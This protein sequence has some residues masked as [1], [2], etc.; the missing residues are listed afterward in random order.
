M[1][2]GPRGSVRCGPF[3]L[4]KRRVSVVRVVGRA[5]GG[6]GL[7]KLHCSVDGTCRV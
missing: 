4:H 3:V 5:V 7:R 1:V 2:T 6:G